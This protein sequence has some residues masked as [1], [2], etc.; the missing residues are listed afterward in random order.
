MVSAVTDVIDVHFEIFDK[1]KMP[2]SIILTMLLKLICIRKDEGTDRIDTIYPD[3]F[4]K[5]LPNSEA[6]KQM[7]IRQKNYQEKYEKLPLFVGM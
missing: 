2:L 6:G 1:F 3:L 4:K 5:N 7:G